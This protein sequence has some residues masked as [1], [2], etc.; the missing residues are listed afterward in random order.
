MKWI[1]NIQSDQVANLIRL[2]I[3]GKLV[4]QLDVVD[5][6]FAVKEIIPLRHKSKTHTADGIAAIRAVRLHS[7]I[8]NE[9]IRISQAITKIGTTVQNRLANTNIQILPRPHLQ[10]LTSQIPILP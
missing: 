10:P 5:H 9:R 2:Q 8:K 3:A 7:M 1:G 4:L 6:I